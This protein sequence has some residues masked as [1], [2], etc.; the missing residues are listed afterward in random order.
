MAE[1]FSESTPVRF[2]A[3]LAFLRKKAGMTQQ[4]VADYLQ[5]H[6]TTYTKYETRCVTPDQEGLVRLANLFGVTVDFLLG[7]SDEPPANVLESGT[8][9]LRLTEQEI[10]LILSFRHL[11][12]EQ[13]DALLE[14]AQ[15][16]K[17]ENKK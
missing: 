9:A 1:R 12:A 16:Y 6:R 5:I 3:R 17:D 14:Q 10:Q 7:V 4:A 8:P 2:G 11:S 15:T 13:K